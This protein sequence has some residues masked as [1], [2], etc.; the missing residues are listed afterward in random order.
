MLFLQLI[1]DSVVLAGIVAV[2]AYLFMAQAAYK[3]G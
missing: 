3:R 1:F 2:F